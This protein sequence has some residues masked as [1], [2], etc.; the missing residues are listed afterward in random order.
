MS[1]S[2][3][4]ATAVWQRV[5]AD[6]FRFLC[7]RFYSWILGWSCC[8]LTAVKQ[9]LI[10]APGP[11]TPQ[12]QTCS[13]LHLFPCFYL[14]F[15]IRHMLLFWRVFPVTSCLVIAK[16][17]EPDTA[18]PAAEAAAAAPRRSV[19]RSVGHRTD[20]P[21]CTSADLNEDRMVQWGENRCFLNL[22]V[23]VRTRCWCHH[24]STSATS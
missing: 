17:C 11:W 16:R 3:Q 4:S 7:L 9:Q 19:G 23:F 14:Y 18:G 13:V 24:C 6:L 22:W 21:F 15:F 12:A 20:S 8:R 10:L 1:G 2:L 5:H